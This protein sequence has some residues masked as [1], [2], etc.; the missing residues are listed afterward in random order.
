MSAHRIGLIG[1]GWFAPFHVEALRGL[2]DRAEIVWAADPDADKARHIADDAGCRPLADYREG[3]GDVDA[4]IAIV[5]HHLHHPITLECLAAG[6]HVLLE[7]P[8]A[9][10]LAQCDEM[11]EAA[12]RAS[13]TLMIALPHRYRQCMQAFRRHVTDGA[14]GPLC[15]LDALMDESMQGYALG[16]LSR[17]ETLGG[18]VF[19]SSSP[20]MID[21]MLWIAGPV[22]HAEMVGTSTGLEM[23]GEDTA[24]SIMKFESGAIGMTRHTWGSPRSNTWYTMRAMCRDG[25]VTLTS[26]PDGDFFNEGVRC[27]WKTR[28]TALT[29]NGEMTLLE[30][31]E[32]LD[33]R[34]EVEHFLDCVE[35][36]AEPQTGGRTARAIIALVE[37]AYARADA[38]GANVP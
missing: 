28:I 5:P 31:D 33:L 7:K 11:I 4:V 22:R 15:M 3:L 19:F 36:G 9:N 37:G 25:W 21:P 30:S 35:S 6:R 27:P 2:R 12:E 34:P 14:Y 18:G 32:G 8:M 29:A 26:T 16:W 20:H 38:D 1:C 17:R 10:T 23:E 24:A 13:R